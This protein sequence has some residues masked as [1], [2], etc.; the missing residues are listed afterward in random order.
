MYRARKKKE[1]KK[2]YRRF[3]NVLRSWQEMKLR[4][5]PAHK[6]TPVLEGNPPLAVVRRIEGPRKGMCAVC[7]VSRLE[8][9]QPSMTKLI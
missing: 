1:R 8:P 4:P 2:I 7:R 6:L 3:E 9:L 5:S